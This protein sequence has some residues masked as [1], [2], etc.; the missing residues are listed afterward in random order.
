MSS[1]L[2][3]EENIFIFFLISNSL[4]QAKQVQSIK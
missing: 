3:Q 2:I 1:I 4:L